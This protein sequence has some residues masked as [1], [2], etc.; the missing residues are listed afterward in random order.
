MTSQTKHYIEI[1]DL[2]TLRCD[3]KN[4]ETSLSL[5]LNDSATKSLGCCPSCNK[6][7]AQ[8]QNQKEISVFVRQ[9]EALKML[10]HTMGFNLYLEVSGPVFADHGA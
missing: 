6:D 4:C 2:L 7:W 10:V 9:V 8:G 5:A 1:K 3:C